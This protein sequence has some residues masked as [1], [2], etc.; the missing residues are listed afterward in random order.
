MEVFFLATAMH[1]ECQKAAQAELDAVVGPARLPDMGDR[2]ALPYLD[3]V[4]MEVY[5]C[6]WRSDLC[7]LGGRCSV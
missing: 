6:V 3:A 4:L 7:V 1:P 5:R 2:E